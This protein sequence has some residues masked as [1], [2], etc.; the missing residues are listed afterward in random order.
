[1]KN[2]PN[3]PNSPNRPWLRRFAT[4]YRVRKKRVVVGFENDRQIFYNIKSILKSS[5]GRL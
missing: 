2:S 1:M 3:S 5:D 4:C